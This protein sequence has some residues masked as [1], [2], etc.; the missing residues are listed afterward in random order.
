MQTPWDEHCINIQVPAK[1]ESQPNLFL[2]MGTQTNS[3]V[4]PYLS[5]GSGLI[6]ISGLYTLGPDGANGARIAALIER[7]SP[8]IR[9]LIRGERLYRDDEQ[10]SPTR[11]HID[12]TLGSVRIAGR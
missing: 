8:N 2:T 11:A 3:F 4:A 5:P 7:Y 6:N 9:M 12:D 1:L 10:R